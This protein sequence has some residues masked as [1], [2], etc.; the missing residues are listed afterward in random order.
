[1]ITI[2]EV[3]TKKDLKDFVKFPF[4]LYK[5]SPYW[6]PPIISQEIKTF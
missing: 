6:V 2:K 1:M 4:K 3:K 5:N